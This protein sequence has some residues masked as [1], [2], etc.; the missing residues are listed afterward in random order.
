MK[1][2]LV[3]NAIT[4]PDICKTLYF[5][6]IAYLRCSADYWWICK[7]KGRCEDERLHEVWKHFGNIYEY[8]SLL[9]I[10]TADYGKM[11]LI[12]QKKSY[13]YF[14]QIFLAP[15]FSCLKMKLRFE[16]FSAIEAQ[17]LWQWAISRKQKNTSSR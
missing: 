7:E 9:R 13:A 15:C 10:K 6:W 4:T 16:L 5:W 12:I 3:L 17:F 14:Y 1:H 11:S 8:T 2:S